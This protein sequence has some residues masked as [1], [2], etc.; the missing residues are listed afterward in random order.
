MAEIVPINPLAEVPAL[1]VKSDTLLG[2]MCSQKLEKWKPWDD[3]PLPIEVTP[4]ALSALERDLAVMLAPIRP[5]DLAAHIESLRAHYGEWADLDIG[6]AKRVNADWLAD[7]EGY[8]AG[9]FVEA[10]R[11]WRNS[12]AKNPPT[13]GQLKAIVSS[14]EK[15]L[16]HVG[17]QAQKARRSMPKKPGAA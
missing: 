7:F 10:C 8:P 3:E 14:D 9:L 12:A 6:L 2:S 4:A 1:N 15:R 13:P 5:N 11:R 16:K 17:W